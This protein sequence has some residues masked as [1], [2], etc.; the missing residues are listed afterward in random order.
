MEAALWVLGAG[1]VITAFE[2][3]LKSA[4][5]ALPPI[6]PC[7]ERPSALPRLRCTGEDAA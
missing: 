1:V 7:R 3:W 5:W 4:L 6:D 2:L